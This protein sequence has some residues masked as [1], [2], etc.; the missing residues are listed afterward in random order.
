MQ[1]SNRYS[2]SEEH[3]GSNKSG[4]MKNA[5]EQQALTGWTAQ[6]EQQVRKAVN[7]GEKQGLTGWTA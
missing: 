5:G 7:A 4:K 2:Q 1:G 6:R 3:R